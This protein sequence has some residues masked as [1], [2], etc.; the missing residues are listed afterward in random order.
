MEYGREEGGWGGSWDVPAGCVEPQ[1]ARV[2]EPQEAF[3]RPAA[4]RDMFDKIDEMC[5]AQGAPV[6]DVRARESQDRRIAKIDGGCSTPR[7][8]FSEISF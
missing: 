1:V 5:V 8:H 7:R 2:L 6:L 3:A 4:D